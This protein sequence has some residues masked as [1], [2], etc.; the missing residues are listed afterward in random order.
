MK[1]LIVYYSRTGTTKIV[2]NE[3]AKKLEADSEEI[4]DKKNRKGAINWI[5]AG[6]DAV[7]GRLTNIE[8]I[9]YNPA[10]YDLVLV[11]SPT[12]AGRITPAIKTF[13]RNNIE[14]IKKLAIF[15]TQGSD[16]RQAAIDDF[17]KAFNK[18]DMPELW[19]PTKDVIGNNYEEKI[20]NFISK[21]K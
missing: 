21:V 18:A 4:I 8:D 3:L 16:K 7:L 20:N 5:I 1:I 11:G 12:W 6:R 9:R 10:D 17:K 14:K 2:A 15:T 19:V 13:T